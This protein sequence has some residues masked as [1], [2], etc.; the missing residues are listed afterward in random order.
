MRNSRKLAWVVGCALLACVVAFAGSAG[1]QSP[2]QTVVLTFASP[3][4]LPTVTLPAGTYTFELGGPH[5]DTVTILGEHNRYI[6]R[7]RVLP[8]KRSNP[9]PAA[10]MFREASATMAPRIANLYFA[11]S[12]EGV[13]FVYPKSLDVRTA[14][15]ESPRPVGTSGSR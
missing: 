1:A 12:V 13:E 11:G 10:A 3:V 14:E 6:A 2:Q 8:A 5:L 9:G 7:T 15:A 4:S